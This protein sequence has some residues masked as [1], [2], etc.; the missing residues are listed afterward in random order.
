MCAVITRPMYDL[1][2]VCTVPWHPGIAGRGVLPCARLEVRVNIHLRR[3]HAAKQLAADVAL[4]VGPV[5]GQRRVEHPEPRA[6]QQAL[7]SAQRAQR[8]LRIPAQGGAAAVT[9]SVLALRRTAPLWIA[10]GTKARG[11]TCVKRPPHPSAPMRALLKSPVTQSWEREL[12]CR[13]VCERL[14]EA[15]TW[16]SEGA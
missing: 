4:V 16:A 2:W 3:D 9:A 8:R 1:T 7:H 15:V 10:L 12:S 13:A 11:V 5:A 6:L 14:A